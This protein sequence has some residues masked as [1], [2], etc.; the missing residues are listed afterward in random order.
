MFPPR[1]V[2]ACVP[3]EP[4]GLGLSHSRLRPA[5]TP[6]AARTAC[7]NCRGYRAC[8]GA[9]VTKTMYGIVRRSLH[10]HHA[11]LAAQKSQFGVTTTVTK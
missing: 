11:L 4:D 1:S 2:P 3:S 9:L 6:Q 7:A 8:R 5:S 10:G